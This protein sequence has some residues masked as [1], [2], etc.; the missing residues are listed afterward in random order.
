MKG[1]N[2]VCLFLTIVPVILIAASLVSPWWSLHTSI[3]A[4]LTLNSEFRV[5][6]NLFKTVSAVLI[7]ENDVQSVTTDLANLTNPQD[8]NTSTFLFMDVT[9]SLVV[10][11]LVL[12]IL[13]VIATIT[14]KIKKYLRYTIIMG[15]LSSVILFTSSW[16]FVLE[17]PAS[18]S[19]L[20]TLTP[21]DLPKNWP[22][23]MSSDIGSAWGAKGVPEGASLLTL[24]KSGNFWIWQP[25]TGWYLH[26][27]ASLV[28]ALV[29]M[30]LHHM[31]I[32]REDKADV[33]ET[34]I[35]N[36]EK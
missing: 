15:Y 7:T 27:L 3:E 18:F 6:Y 13:M 1:T 5:D 23:I 21:I 34:K 32:Q 29:S 4:R 22:D 24:L 2:A 35:L 14:P 30:T 16:Y 12:S 25:S 20:S 10:M 36:V 9:L 19:T 11:G 26:L 33:T 31:M 28:V 8:P 17:L